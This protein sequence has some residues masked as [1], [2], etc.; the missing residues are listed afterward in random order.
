LY[1]P[2]DFNPHNRYPIVEITY[3]AATGR[4]GPTSFSDNFVNAA[5]NA[6]A[7][8]ELGFIVVA[9]DGRGTSYRSRQFHDAFLGTEDVFGA[10]DHVA[11][12]R[13]LA[14]AR[15]YMDLERVGVTGHSFGGYGSLRAMLLYPDFFKV[16]VSGVGPGAWQEFQQSVSVE[17]YFGVPADDPKVLEYYDLISNTRLAKRLKGKLLLIYGGLDENVPLKH[18]FV[19]F[20]ALIKANVD[21]DTLI[22]PDAPHT[23]GLYPYAVARTLK[24]F[25][26]YLGGPVPARN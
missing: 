1:K 25:R 5:D 7:L 22:M 12:I 4:F 21:F 2:S 11:A 19:L 18:A 13:N 17:R 26:D 16:A 3:P 15:P 14:A 24:Y 6:A 23:A 10:A 8:A 20:D 9:I